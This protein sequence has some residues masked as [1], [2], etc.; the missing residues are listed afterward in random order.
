MLKIVLPILV[1]VS[2][3]LS[4]NP[5]MPSATC[6]KSPVN[7]PM[8]I[9][10]ILRTL[11]NTNCMISTTVEKAPSNT[12]ANISHNVSHAVLI[13]SV[14][15]SKLKPNSFILLT[16]S[17]AKSE[18]TF[19]NSLNVFVMLFLNSSFVFH[20]VTNI[21]TNVPT[22]A[23]TPRAGAITELKVVAIFVITLGIPPMLAISSDCPILRSCTVFV[24][25]PITP[26]AVL[27]T[28]II[29]PIVLATF[30]KISKTGPIAAITRPAFTTKFCC[31]SDNSLNFVTRF[32]RN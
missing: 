1:N 19:F 27:T 31:S 15:P 14:M 26:L 2:T 5:F 10:I 25:L 16:N 4:N 17:F 12:G 22:T 9:S 8:N 13:T 7:I 6:S 28:V 21:A 30:D 20:N 11:F 32:V 3:T 29:I 23:T 24:T 18:N